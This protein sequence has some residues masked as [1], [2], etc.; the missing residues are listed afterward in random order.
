[1]DYT[2]DPNSFKAAVVVLSGGQDSA[3][4]L[5]LAC[6]KH[7]SEKVAAITFDYGQRHS[8]EVECAKKLAKHFDVK[9]HKIVKLPFYSQLTSNALFDKNAE[10]SKEPGAKRPNTY[11]EGRNPLFLL[12]A[13]IWA[14]SL[15]AKKLYTGVSQVD[16][17]GYPDCRESFIRAQE[18]AIRLAME[19]PFE[20]ITPFMRMTK[21]DEWELADKL[22]ILELVK[23]G[24]I[25]CYNGIPGA[26]CGKCPACVLRNN[27]LK[28]YEKT[29]KK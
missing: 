11:V 10:I 3:T 13:A 7:G 9:P 5:A 15:G 22:G 8:A 2:S 16:S 18:K 17:S 26:G 14:K 6:N 1:M 28:E 20:I 29:A 23:T 4:C 12:I 25:T 27:G 21:R 19:W 24:T